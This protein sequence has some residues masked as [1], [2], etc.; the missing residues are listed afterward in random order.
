ML[1]RF[2]P[3]TP[4]TQFKYKHLFA[5]SHNIL[6]CSVR[7]LDPLVDLLSKLC[8]DDHT[9]LF[10]KKHA[11]K[12]AEAAGVSLTRASQVTSQLPAPGTK[13]TPE[14]L[15][16]V[17]FLGLDRIRV[18]NATTIGSDVQIRFVS[19]ST[20]YRKP[21][22]LLPMRDWYLHFEANFWLFSSL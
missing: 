16:K 2:S 3:A 5:L 1:N 22:I 21:Y 13:M 6:P 10:L 19:L 7:D 17:I 18:W 9:K 8:E 15:E 12:T 20:G 14:E 11:E 4:V